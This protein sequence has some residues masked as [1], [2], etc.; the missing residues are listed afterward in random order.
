MAISIRFLRFSFT[1]FFREKKPAIRNGRQISPHATQ[2][3]A[4]RYPSMMCIALDAGATANTAASAMDALSKYFSFF[5]IFSLL[6]DHNPV[7]SPGSFESEYSGSGI[8]TDVPPSHRLPPAVTSVPSPS[9]CC[10]KYNGMLPLC[11]LHAFRRGAEWNIAPPIQQRVLRGIL[12]RLPR[13]FSD[14]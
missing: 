11:Y 1:L 13:I 10:Q 7:I 5:G 9:V 14:N 2:Y 6:F 8:I 3:P 4:G 12:T